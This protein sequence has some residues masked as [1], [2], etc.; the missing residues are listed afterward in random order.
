MEI[1]HGHTLTHALNW[2]SS[3]IL[4]MEWNICVNTMSA[5]E[6]ACDEMDERRN[7]RVCEMRLSQE[8]NVNDAKKYFAWKSSHGTSGCDGKSGSGGIQCN[9]SILMHLQKF[10]CTG[11]SLLCL[12]KLTLA[13]AFYFHC[14]TLHTHT[15]ERA[16]RVFIRRCIP[17]E[18]FASGVGTIH[19]VNFL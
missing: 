9:R 5:D 12:C 11:L 2:V 8:M 16:I 14:Y 10:I 6:T 4:K 19:P 15:L 3:S 1:A 7:G 18:L 13:L 17:C